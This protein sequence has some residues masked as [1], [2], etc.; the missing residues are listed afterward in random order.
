MGRK[1][2]LNDATAEQLA[3]VA[4]LGKKRAKALVDARD[5]LGGFT[6]WKQVDEVSGV[7]P[8]ALKALQDSADLTM[9][10]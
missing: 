6:D 4:G 10:R 8:A 1:W 7:G 2:S 9:G 5:R 3:S